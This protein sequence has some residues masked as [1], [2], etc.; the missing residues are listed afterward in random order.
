MNPD[1]T[2]LA[3]VIQR[4]SELWLNEAVRLRDTVSHRYEL[5]GITDVVCQLPKPL[6]PH[7]S[8]AT[9][10]PMMATGDPVEDFVEKLVERLIPFIVE[11]GDLLPL[12]GARLCGNAAEALNQLPW[13]RHVDT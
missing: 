4:H 6:P 11:S 8:I 13:K 2:A 1:T 9:L 10:P 3:D 7:A 5:T 12:D